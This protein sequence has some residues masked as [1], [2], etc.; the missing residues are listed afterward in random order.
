MARAW[1]TRAHRHQPGD[2]S[3]WP[4]GLND[5]A[6]PRKPEN[7]PPHQVSSSGLKRPS[8]TTP[9]VPLPTPVPGGPPAAGGASS[10]PLKPPPGTPVPSHDFQKPPIPSQSTHSALASSSSIKVQPSA[11]HT[12]AFAPSPTATASDAAQIYP[13]A[14][15][16]ATTNTGEDADNTPPGSHKAMANS[17]Q[18]SAV[19]KPQQNSTPGRGSVISSSGGGGSVDDGLSVA[20]PAAA[21]GETQDK[22][23]KAITGVLVT[24]C[25]SVVVV[26]GVL[27]RRKV[28]RVKAMALPFDKKKGLLIDS[29]SLN[30]D[31]PESPHSPLDDIFVAPGL[32]PTPPR[33]AAGDKGEACGPPPLAPIE[34][35][36]RQQG[37]HPPAM[38]AT[39][40][41]TGSGQTSYFAGFRLNTYFPAAVSILPGLW[42]NQKRR[43]ASIPSILYS[44]P[45]PLASLTLAPAPRDDGDKDIDGAADFVMP[46][47]KTASVAFSDGDGD[48]KAASSPAPLSDCDSGTLRSESS[49]T[50]IR[51]D[52]ESDTSSLSRHLGPREDVGPQT[53]SLSPLPSIPPVSPTMSVQHQR[54]RSWS[55]CTSPP[56]MVDT[57][58]RRTSAQSLGS[59]S[60]ASS[61]MS[62][63]SSAPES[64]N[65]DSLSRYLK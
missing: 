5:P 1:P 56:S 19:F 63:A 32:F 25:M 51:S 57:V 45:L 8:K 42:P 27:Y 12:M 29:Q 38:A 55:S 49:T 64:L 59:Q 6:W 36:M 54:H 23:T 39:Q 50:S 24:A 18:G 46:I 37:I 62:D 35:S 15:Y 10:V 40:K 47:D 22:A 52:I 9:A 17:F 61:E 34:N 65:A 26:G 20:G 7:S 4:A 3:D 41:S 2:L 30:N 48:R 31:R 53:P 13:A 43:K 33:A 11:T 60:T 16:L 28:N 44:N 58:D 21:A 14:A